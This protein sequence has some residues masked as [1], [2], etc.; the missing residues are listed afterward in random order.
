MTEFAPAAATQKDS[1]PAVF[2]CC[3]YLPASPDCQFLPLALSA[4]C[5][6]AAASGLF[7]QHTWNTLFTVYQPYPAGIGNL[8]WVSAF[9]LTVTVEGPVS[10]LTPNPVQL[11]L[12][13]KQ[14]R[15][16]PRQLRLHPGRLALRRPGDSGSSQSHPWCDSF[17]AD[18]SGQPTG[19]TSNAKHR[20]TSGR[21]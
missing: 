19:S 1:P 13:Q 8:V 15:L 18:D 21:G 7:P 17:S 12:H 3:C 14:L 2:A 6:L 10:Q 9:L 11:R 20:R 16:R 5:L 4:H